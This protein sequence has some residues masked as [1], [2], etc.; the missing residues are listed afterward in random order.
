MGKGTTITGVQVACMIYNHFKTEDH[1][2]QVY[3]FND[4]ADLNWY[5]DTRMAEFLA[6]WGFILENIEPAIVATLT[7]N[8]ER[9]RGIFSSGRWRNRP[10]LPKM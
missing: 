6:Q 3:G 8:G 1:M 10:S 9:R 4:M 7:A 5:S 2:S